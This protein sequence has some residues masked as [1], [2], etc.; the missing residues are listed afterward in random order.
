MNHDNDETLQRV[1]D[2]EEDL[3]EGGAAVGD[4]QHSGH[5]GEGQE[6]Q[7]HAGA[8]QRC[9]AGRENNRLD[10]TGSR[11]LQ[12]TS[13]PLLAELCSLLLFDCKA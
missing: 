9:P 3:E 5:P 6:G 10:T 12:W 7:N 8:P 13:A 2:S 11:R 1:E 4:G